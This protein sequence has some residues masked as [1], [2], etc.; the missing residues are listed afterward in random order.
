MSNMNR[1]SFLYFIRR[2]FLIFLSICGI[3]GA[4]SFSL[5]YGGDKVV[6]PNSLATP[7]VSPYQNS[8]SGIGLVE[9][10]SRNINIGAYA[11][12]IVSQVLVKEGQEVNIDDPLF[13]QDQRSAL[14]EVR[15]AHDG[16][17][18]AK[19]HAELAEVNIAD[20]LD[21][22]T[23]AKG[24]KKGRDITEEELQDRRF[25]YE[26]AVADLAVKNGLIKQAETSLR[27]AEVALDKTTVHSPIDGLVLKVRIR[28]GEFISG[29]EQDANSPLLIGSH[30]PLY[31]R[32]QIDENDLWRFDKS[33]PAYAFLRSNKKIS[34]P[35][36]F[37]RIEP[38]AGA[39]ENLR[40][41]GTELIDTRIIDVI[42]EIKNN[43][44]NLVIGQ[45]LDVF[46]ESDKS[47]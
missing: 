22:Y 11:P 40:G 35:L 7:P 14:T 38:Y 39:K 45:Q 3:A 34:T 42:Y 19:L 18:V 15:N 5:A 9:A 28:P 37:V 20:Q 30:K 17:H 27:L 24:L 10:S 21:K 33:K 25:A 6:P 16:L 2:N 43:L 41:S 8:I 31:L 29:N 23:R 12:G 36:S 44:A 47:P 13:V 26:R 46:I 1:N 4:V 32:V